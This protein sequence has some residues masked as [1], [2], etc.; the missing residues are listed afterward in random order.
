ME[1]SQ[2]TTKRRFASLLALARRARQTLG[3]FPFVL[4][5]AIGAAIVAHHLAGI[6]FDEGKGSQAFY[7]LLMSLILGIPLFTSLRL[8][9]KSRGWSRET[10]LKVALVGLA[11]LVAYYATLPFPIKGADLFRYF[12]LIAA[13]HLFLAFVPFVG[14]RGEEDGFWQYNRV[15]FLR[16]ALAALYSAVLYIGLTL[17]LLACQTLLDIDFN[18][19]I[20]LQLWYWIVLVYNTWFF[21]SGIPEDTRALQQV[22]EYPTGLRI[23]TQYVLIPLV[24]IYMVILYTYLGKIIV[25]WNLP[26]GWVGYPVIG[27]SV[28]GMLALLLVYPIRER[29]ENAWIVTYARYFYWAL[30]PLIALIAVAIWTRI[31]EYGITEKRYAVV[32]ATVWLLGI[33]VYFTFRRRK[34]IRIIPVTLCIG[35]LLTAFGPWGATSVSRDSQLARLRELLVTNQVMVA[36][37]L[38]QTPKTVEFEQEQEISSIVQYLHVVHGLDAIRGWYAQPERLPDDLTAE[39]A[40][41][42]MGL[43]YR[44]LGEREDRFSISAESPNPLALEGFDYIYRVS[45]RLRED[46]LRLHVWLDDATELSLEGTLLQLGRPGEPADRLVVDIAPLVID[47][48]DRER[49]GESYG[50]E[51]ST[52]EAENASFRL[53][54]YVDEVSGTF[55][56][57]SLEI[58]YLRATTLVQV[59]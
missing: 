20:Y 53:V 25:E 22:H 17:A 39:L 51:A 2:G 52:L 26:K 33:A 13:V 18:R 19:M 43:Q 1:S 4:L 16:F 10:Q 3:R 14:R 15:L 9:G 27:V 11:A 37:T 48:R 21:L 7:P 24:V 54:F 35:T 41:E 36:G 38:V 49:R 44:A 32:V 34:D 28:T 56:A 55:A 6:E 59:K 12:Q 40:L 46:S 58:T 47:L 42:Q 45:A 29:A 50:L 30:F 5:S 31:S 57:D 23:F 8:L